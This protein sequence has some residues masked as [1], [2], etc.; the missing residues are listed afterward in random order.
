MTVIPLDPNTAKGRLI[1]EE[2]TQVIAE[3]RLAIRERSKPPRPGTPV[4]SAPPR[5]KPRPV[6]PAQPKKGAAA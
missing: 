1:A 3:V 2:L 6:G 5:P 4:P